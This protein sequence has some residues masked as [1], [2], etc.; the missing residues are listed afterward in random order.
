MFIAKLYIGEEEFNVLEYSVT[1]NANQ[2]LKTE[3]KQV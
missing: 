3:K 1:M 2:E